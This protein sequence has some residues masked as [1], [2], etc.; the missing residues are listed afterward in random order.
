MTQRIISA[1]VLIALIALPIWWGGLLFLTAVIVIATVAV[2]EFYDLAAHSGYSAI[3]LLGTVA[4]LLIIVASSQQNPVLWQLGVAILVF[5][6]LIWELLSPTVDG[7]LREWALTLV[8]VLYIGWP[9]SMIVSLR[10]GPDGIVWILLILIGTAACDSMA[11]ISGHLFGRQPF[12]PKY[13]PKKTW[14]GTFGGIL[15]CLVAVTGFG[16]QFL[17]FPIWQIALLGLLI[18]PFAIVG[19][20]AES[21]IKRRIGVKDSSDLIPGHGGILDRVDSLLFT[22]T[23]TYFVAQWMLS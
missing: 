8:G 16:A 20:L 11:Y 17:N 21:M 23:V 13:S 9:A 10:V 6:G 3:R 19:D 4:L 14:E 15:G 22:I 1:L 12:A 2:W 7:K 18:G 5:G